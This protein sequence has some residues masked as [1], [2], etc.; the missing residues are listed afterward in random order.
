MV[1]PAIPVTTAN[2]LRRST[3][4][5]VCD[6]DYIA[7]VFG[8]RHYCIASPLGFNLVVQNLLSP[9]PKN[10]IHTSTPITKISQTAF[11][12]TL[13]SGTEESF[14]PFEKIVL[15]TPS[16]ISATLLGTMAN[17]NRELCKALEKFKFV[18][19]LVVTHTDSSFVPASPTLQRDLHFQRPEA[20][21][22]SPISSPISLPTSSPIP[23]SLQKFQGT[24]QATHILHHRSPFLHSHPL[25]Q[26]TNP[27]NYPLKE[28][29]LSQH[30]FERY[31]PTLESL[32]VRREYFGSGG[33]AQGGEGIWFVGS[34][35]GGGIPLLEGCVKSAE[36]V[37]EGI[38]ERKGKDR[39]LKW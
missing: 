22:S 4:V 31:L 5:N 14:G 24:T 21:I 16:G 30:W 39:D 19:A 13:H 29:I 18:K 9:I 34:W 17:S 35:V 10:Q 33:C 15:A 27:H 2:L 38:L 11:Q 23:S 7:A 1:H 32:K 20:A 26:T 6:V 3:K 28:T 37:V 36:G 8:T 12:Y 25:Y